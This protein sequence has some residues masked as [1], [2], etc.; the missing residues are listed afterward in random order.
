M[1]DLLVGLYEN[2]L[3]LDA[4]IEHI[5]GEIEKIAQRQASCQR[6]MSVP[7]I[8]PMIST[9]WLQPLVMAKPSSVAEILAPGLA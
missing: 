1:A 7:G 2:W 8:G 5:S 4:R 9:P 3:W 6:L